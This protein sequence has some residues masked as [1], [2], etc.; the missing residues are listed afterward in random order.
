MNPADFNTLTILSVGVIEREEIYEL[1]PYYYY[2]GEIYAG[3]V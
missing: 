2:S 1:R 3:E